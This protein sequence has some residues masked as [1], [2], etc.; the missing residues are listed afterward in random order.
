MAKTLD[1]VWAHC[2]R[3][4]KIVESPAYLALAPTFSEKLTHSAFQ[5]KLALKLDKSISVLRVARTK[6]ALPAKLGLEICKS[7]MHPNWNY[8]EVW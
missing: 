4:H 2:V 5:R 6:P 7:G 8:H 1:F 3:P